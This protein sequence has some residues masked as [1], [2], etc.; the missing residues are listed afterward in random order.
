VTEWIAFR[1]PD[2][3]ML[4]RRLKAAVVFDGRNIYD[5]KTVAAAGL[6]YHSIGRVAHVG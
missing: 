4:K 1:S 2:F 3:D 5:P 6:N